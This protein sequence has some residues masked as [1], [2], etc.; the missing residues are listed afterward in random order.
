MLSSTFADLREADSLP[1][2]KTEPP[3]NP[4]FEAVAIQP[5]LFCGIF[6]FLPR[7]FPIPL[8]KSPILWYTVT[9]YYRAVQIRLTLFVYHKSVS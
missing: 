3:V 5:P 2:S 9:E 4:K 7:N 8:A 6:R 1:Y